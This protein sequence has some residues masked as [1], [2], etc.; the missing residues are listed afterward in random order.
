MAGGRTYAPGFQPI[1][2]VAEKYYVTRLQRVALLARLGSN[3]YSRKKSDRSGRLVKRHQLLSIPSHKRDAVLLQDRR[4]P[5][6]CAVGR[7]TEG[8]NR[9]GAGDLGF[10]ADAIVEELAHSVTHPVN[11]FSRVVEALCLNQK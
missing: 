10:V 6:T 4:D 7:R 9:L 1:P 2:S 11:G 5:A 8:Q 3:A